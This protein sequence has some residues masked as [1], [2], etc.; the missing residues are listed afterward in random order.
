MSCVGERT[1]RAFPLTWVFTR[2]TASWRWVLLL[3]KWLFLSLVT[4]SCSLALV[5]GDCLLSPPE[6]G[7]FPPSVTDSCLIALVT[8][9]GCLI[10]SVTGGGVG[11]TSSSRLVSDWP[12]DR[13]CLDREVAWCMLLPNC[14]SWSC[15]ASTVSAV[16]LLSRQ[17]SLRSF[18]EVRN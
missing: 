11:S 5:T 18:S 4:D 13:S 10:V 3:S 8:G 14:F 7:C 2:F 1:D 16:K 6:G 9:G 17:S 12:S 15:A